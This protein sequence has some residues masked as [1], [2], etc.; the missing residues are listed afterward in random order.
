MSAK[1]Q[2][3]LLGF[4]LVALIGAEP[5]A[6]DAS[7]AIEGKLI[8]DQR[9]HISAQITGER[10]QRVK[11]MFV[12]VGDIVKQGDRLARLDTE[13][14][15]A[16]RLIAQRALE[17]AQASVEVATSNV[18]RAK[19]EYDRRAGLKSS[20]SFNRAE[21]EN[22]EVELRA[23]ESQ[24]KSVQSI[25]NRRDAEMARID[26]EMRLSEITAPYDGLVVEI[27]TSV[28]ASVTQK[29]PDLL[30]LLNL[31][32]LEIAVELSHAEAQRLK[33]GQSVQYALADGE[34][35]RARVRAVLPG[36]SPQGTASVTRLQ[37]DN[38]DLPLA[39]RRQQPVQ[40][41]LED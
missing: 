9:G 1:F 14:L 28:G 12:R 27:L 22:A 16:D 37:L 20:P 13:Q 17:E 18:A 4:A 8:A 23:A 34:K 32:Q 21:F 31:S 29:S 30:T 2:L 38:I 15:E 39:V 25:A 11:D 6:V 40:L 3:M 41:Y 10:S 7:E 24:L 35:R 5:R 26:L 33:P 36:L 19:L